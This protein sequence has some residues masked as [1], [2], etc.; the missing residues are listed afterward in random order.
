MGRRGP[1]PM[2]KALKKRR[3]TYRPSRAAKDAMDLPVS[4]PGMPEWLDAEGRKEW[5]RVV[6]MLE[7]AK[8]LADVDRIALG[9][10]CAA[11][12]LCINATR[13]Y[14]R[15]GVS[16]TK[17]K[18]V[19]VHPMIK[20]AQEARAQALRLGAEFG[21]TPAS[22]TRVSGKAAKTG[23]EGGGKKAD[24]DEKFLF[25]GAPKLEVVK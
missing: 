13:E 22:R 11:V 1:V 18:R 25:D 6:P 3:G 7:E 8:V 5:E 15:H 16:L 14:Q 21:L 12:S 4:T 23:H 24:D 2:P 19:Y 17:N 9:N 10:Y 20:V